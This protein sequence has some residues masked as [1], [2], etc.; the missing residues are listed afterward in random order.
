MARNL[1]YCKKKP[2]GVSYVY[3]VI[4]RRLAP[5]AGTRGSLVGHQLL[6]H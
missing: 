6:V 3:P 5:S 4:L 2:T 1:G